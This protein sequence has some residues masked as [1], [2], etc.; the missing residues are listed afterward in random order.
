[1]RF[2]SSKT[3]KARHKDINR[4]PREPWHH[5]KSESTVIDGVID[6][7]GLKCQRWKV[8]VEQA[9]SRLLIF[10]YQ[11]SSF[12]GKERH[13]WFQYVLWQYTYLRVVCSIDQFLVNF[14]KREKDKERGDRERERKRWREKEREKGRGRERERERQQTKERV[15]ESERERERETVRVK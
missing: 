12:C 1:M 7:N 3:L 9:D 15:R 6:S 11:R 4:N 10:W 8:T 5:S 14:E 13:K 2:S